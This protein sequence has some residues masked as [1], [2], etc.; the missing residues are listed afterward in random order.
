MFGKSMN[1]KCYIP[2]GVYYYILTKLD[3]LN[4]LIRL[5]LLKYVYIAYLEE[6]NRNTTL[7]AAT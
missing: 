1:P 5:F 3:Y 7:K 2:Y 4:M 6:K